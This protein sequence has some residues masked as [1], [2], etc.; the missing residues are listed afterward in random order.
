M[1]FTV[2]LSQWNAANNP[3]NDDAHPMDVTLLN[4]NGMCCLGFACKSLG[5]SDLA[6]TDVFMPNGIDYTYHEASFIDSGL[7]LFNEDGDALTSPLAREAQRI[8]DSEEL[9]LYEKMR[10]LHE[11][12]TEDGHTITFELKG[13]QV[14]PEVTNA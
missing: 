13:E 1:K 4:C 11:I 5:M 6:I 3:Y 12:F 14:Y 2:E 10:M 7:V 8:N 9:D